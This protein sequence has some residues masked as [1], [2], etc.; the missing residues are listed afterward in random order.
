MAEFTA[1]L[2]KAPS[3]EQVDSDS[4][5]ELTRDDRDLRKLLDRVQHHDGKP[6]KKYGPGS[7]HGN[8]PPA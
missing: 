8:K 6:E 4:S 1:A 2:D 5:R 3:A 7:S